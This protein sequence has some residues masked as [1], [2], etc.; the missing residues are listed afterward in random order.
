MHDKILKIM[1]IFVRSK[2]RKYIFINIYIKNVLIFNRPIRHAANVLLH[3]NKEWTEDQVDQTTGAMFK[4]N[5]ISDSGLPPPTPFLLL[6]PHTS[7]IPFPVYFPSLYSV[8]SRLKVL[9][10][11]IKD[12]EG[13]GSP[14]AEKLAQ[15]RNLAKEKVTLLMKYICKAGPTLKSEG[16]E[17]LLPYI[18]EFFE[19]SMTSVHAAWSLFEP[20]SQILGPQETCKRLLSHLCSLFDGEELTRK[21]MKLYHRSFVIQLLIRLGAGVFLQNFTTLLVEASAGYKNFSAD[22]V[23]RQISSE[24]D[25]FG[26]NGMTEDEY[27]SVFVDEGVLERGEITPVELD[28]SLED[29]VKDVTYGEEALPDDEVDPGETESDSGSVDQPSDAQSMDSTDQAD[30][31]AETS[32]VGSVNEP[33]EELLGRSLGRLSVHSVS[34]LLQEEH[35]KNTAS[36]DNLSVDDLD[37]QLERRASTGSASVSEQDQDDDAGTDSKGEDVPTTALVRSETEEFT[38]A[39]LD[40]GTTDYNINHVA[41]E[42]I[43][44][45]SHRLGPVLTA[46][47]LSRNLLRMLA[48]CYYGEEQLEPA[49]KDGKYIF[50]EIYS[51]L[52]FRC[53]SR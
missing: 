12:L 10:S 2:L 15:I 7:L 20:V 27:P 1:S 3:L 43:K 9:D 38:S 41:A 28:K 26:T 16:M 49:T 17:L 30:M 39:I 52:Y 32:S 23:D 40:S 22:E 51:K 35:E 44:W 45:L 53:K 21:H 4:Y 47:W 46:K 18:T 34:R 5:F 31:F 19:N 36:G 8:L 37:Q 25:V 14:S 42:T 33:N 50:S 11:N 13:L 48:L 24:M 6:H 29:P